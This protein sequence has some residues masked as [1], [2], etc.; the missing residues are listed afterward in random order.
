MFLTSSRHVYTYMLFQSDFKT[1]HSA[2]IALVKVFNYLLLTVQSG[3]SCLSAALI[4]WI[5]KYYCQDLINLLV[6]KVQFW[7]GSN[8]I[9][10]K[11]L[12]LSNISYYFYSSAPLTWAPCFLLY[13]LPLVAACCLCFWE[14]TSIYLF[15]FLLTTFCFILFFLNWIAIIHWNLCWT[16]LLTWNINETV[17]STLLKTR[18][19]PFGFGRMI[20]SKLY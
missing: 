1:W 13:V 16:A 2:E 6:P 5:M 12:F 15:I 18:L 17:Y 7:I 4:L 11:G 14:N 19:R 10:H 9:W 3:D 8:R 20:H